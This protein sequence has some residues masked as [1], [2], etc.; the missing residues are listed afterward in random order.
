MGVL[1]SARV[2]QSPWHPPV[3]TRLSLVPTTSY[4]MSQANACTTICTL[5]GKLMRWISFFARA[6]SFFGRGV[7][8]GLFHSL[9]GV[10]SFPYHSFPGGYIILVSF[11][12]WGIFH[13]CIIIL[14]GNI[15]F[16]YHYFPEPYI[17]LVSLFSRVIYHS[18]IIIFLG[19]ISFL[20]H[21]FPGCY[22]EFHPEQSPLF[23]DILHSH[24]TLFHTFC[25]NSL[26]RNINTLQSL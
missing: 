3:S 24:V 18:H 8:P 6:I 25:P 7:L 23:S 2:H 4:D 21:Y 13:S 12:S 26:L 20:Y 19:N 10:I 16:P 11:F 1:D 9:P 14:L 22:V 5:P 15:S 17:I